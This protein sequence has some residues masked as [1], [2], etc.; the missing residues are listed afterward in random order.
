MVTQNLFA[1]SLVLLLAHISSSLAA[2]SRPVL[3]STHDSLFQKDK[4]SSS[5]LKLASK[6]KI[7]QNN[8]PITSLQQSIFVNITGYAKP[9]HLQVLDE[10]KC[11]VAA[12][13]IPKSAEGANL[14]STRITITPTGEITELELLHPTRWFTLPSFLPDQANETWRTPYPAPRDAILKVLNSYPDGI[15]LGNGANVPVAETCTRY[16]NG[17]GMPLACNGVFWLFQTTVSQRRWY[18]DT[19][20][21][22]AL[23]NFV[24]DQSKTPGMIPQL[25]IQEYF[26]IVDGRI[27][28]IFAAMEPQWPNYQ[29]VWG[30]DG[31][32]G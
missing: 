3:Q 28:E 8:L 7:S 15:A 24:F 23:G 26:K 2:C 32:F 5:S 12:F 20:T 27:F 4:V 14:L 30:V 19:A 21:G 22:N 17:F 16:E 29:D 25:W 11:T 6:V 31:A 1:R 10:E 9:L 13:S 18:V